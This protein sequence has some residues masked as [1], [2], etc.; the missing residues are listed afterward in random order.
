MHATQVKAATPLQGASLPN[1]RKQAH[2]LCLDMHVLNGLP[3]R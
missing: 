2:D 3:Q 1:H